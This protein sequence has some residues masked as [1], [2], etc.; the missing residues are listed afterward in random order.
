MELGLVC[1]LVFVTCMLLFSTFCRMAKG[2][3][4]LIKQR[5][6]GI[7]AGT[8]T[9][10]DEVLAK[11]FR[12]RVLYPAFKGLSD[13]LVRVTPKQIISGL[14]AKIAEAGV[15]FNLGAKEWFS[16]QMIFSF[17]I[18]GATLI[19]ALMLGW[20]GSNVLLVIT[21]EIILGILIPRMLLTSKAKQR[22]KDIVRSLPDVLDL[23]TVSV[24]AGLGFDA[25]LAK[26]V[27]KMPGVLSREFEKAL[28]EIKVGVPRREA[29]KNI[30]M[31][32]GIEEFSTFIASII[33]ADQMGVS[34][35]NIL[36]I[37]SHQ[38]RLSRRQKARERAAKAP[39]KMLIPMVVFIFPIIF[40]VILGPVV[41]RLLGSFLK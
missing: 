22:R 13:F 19:L 2:S 35:G 40:V 7:G 32:V 33:Q 29:L 18:P 1:L 15:P 25:A 10:N 21:A 14:D 30:S 41:I 3:R 27:D 34:I 11:P 31:R 24:E 5:L 12:V 39:V 8:D 23:L 36:R 20:N 4:L 9:E 37:Q 26:V 38:V 16:L 6:D 28:H 17:F